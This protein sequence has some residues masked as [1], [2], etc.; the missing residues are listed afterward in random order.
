M[1]LL[2]VLKE[3]FCVCDDK[4]KN[5]YYISAYDD[6]MRDALKKILKYKNKTEFIEW[7]LSVSVHPT[8]G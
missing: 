6:F 2:K 4:V 5:R 7:I 8:V 3:L 1:E